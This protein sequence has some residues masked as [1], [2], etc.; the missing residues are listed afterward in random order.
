[1]PTLVKVNLFRTVS[2]RIPVWDG[3]VPEW[4]S[5]QTWRWQPAWKWGSSLIAALYSLR[6]RFVIFRWKPHC[7]LRVALWNAASQGVIGC[8]GHFQ[9]DSGGRWESR[10]SPGGCHFTAP[11]PAVWPGLA[12]RLQ[13]CAGSC[14]CG[15]FLPDFL[16]LSQQKGH[17]ACLCDMPRLCFFAAHLRQ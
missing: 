4:T 2:L 3:G 6:C 8:P 17:D 16:Q 15:K 1:M 9:V 12:A 5:V 7:I 13:V 14:L 11:F 10:C